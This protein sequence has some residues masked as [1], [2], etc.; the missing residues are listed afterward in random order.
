MGKAVTA[1][2]GRL[3]VARQLLLV[4]ALIFLAVAVVA[5]SLLIVERQEAL[6]R[7]SRY[8]L[9]WLLSQAAHA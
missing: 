4:S 3:S 6:G 8:N 9:T 1:V 2:F 5:N 7:V